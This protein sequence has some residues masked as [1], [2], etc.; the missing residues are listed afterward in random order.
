MVSQV[1][2]PRQWLVSQVAGQS[3]AWSRLRR[4]RARWA[5][6]VLL[7]LALVFAASPVNA[8]TS[9][10]YHG[11]RYSHTVALTFDDGY[12]GAS[13]SAI[14]DILRRHGVKATFFPTSD[15]VRANPTVWRR[16]AA[17]GYQPHHQPPQPDPARLE[18][19]RLPD[20]AVPLGHQH[21]HRLPP[22]S[23]PASAL[24]RLEPHRPQRRQLRRVP[25]PGALGR[26]QRDAGPERL[27][28]PDAHALE[29]RPGPAV[30]HPEPQGAGLPIRD[31]PADVRRVGRGQRTVRRTQRP[32][33]SG[34]R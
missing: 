27:G 12:S 14:L 10:V 21:R 19:G 2:E 15:A 7:L 20:H 34:S 16:V 22:D 26:R 30:H 31:D 3:S 17:A 5:A 29:H 13:T 24:R 25:L 28:G 11:S 8:A 23:L 18:L 4:R 32:P 1:Q 9:V 33:V 6:P